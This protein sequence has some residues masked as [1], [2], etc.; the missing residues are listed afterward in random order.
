MKNKDWWLEEI[1]GVTLVRFRHF[2]EHSN[3]K[4][5]ITTRN[6]GF[7]N[8]PVSSFNIGFME[9]DLPENVVANRKLLAKSLEIPNTSFVFTRQ[10]HSDHIKKVEPEDMQ[11]GLFTKEDA[12]EDTDGFM[13]SIKG[14]CPVIMVADCVPVILFDPKKKVTGVFHAGW[15]GTV[16]QIA[17]KGLLMMISEYGTDPADIIASIGPS[18]G[19]CCY[20]VGEDVEN[21]VK[22]VF[23]EHANS[24]LL[25]NEM[26]KSNFDLWNANK[27]QLLLKG[28]LEKNIIVCDSCTYHNPET[29]FSWRYNDGKTGRMGA[30]V[31]LKD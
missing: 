14:V 10:T 20:E 30:G 17:Q 21:E 13:L 15:R 2:E 6:T 5:F 25:K 22:K 26:G 27:I 16:K 23:P 3:F 8:D 19:P 18:I 28:V 31:Y 24:L 29:L 7:S 9:D 11:K 1:K 12:I 4:Y